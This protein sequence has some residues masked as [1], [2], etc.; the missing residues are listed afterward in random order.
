MTVIE[1]AFDSW[2]LREGEQ[3][4]HSERVAFVGLVVVGVGFCVWFVM[5]GFI[6]V[7]VFS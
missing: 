2:K 5:V 1:K 4:R 3:E 6:L 7:E